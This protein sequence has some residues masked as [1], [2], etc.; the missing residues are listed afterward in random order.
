MGNKNKITVPRLAD[1]QVE[2]T[3]RDII[4]AM[5]SQDRPYH[6][7]IDSVSDETGGKRVAL[8]QV[9]DKDGVPHA[10]RFLLLTWIT[11]AASGVNSEYGALLGTGA[12]SMTTFSANYDLYPDCRSL[13]PVPSSVDSDGDDRNALS[14]IT[15]DGYG[16]AAINMKPNSIKA[17]LYL[18][19]AA[20]GRVDVAQIDFA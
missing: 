6:A 5:F 20:L 8:I 12:N 9:R 13:L 14:F 11:H 16:R 2:R 1:P 19:V 10:G 3:L 18:H 7:S 15:T 4:L 17:Q